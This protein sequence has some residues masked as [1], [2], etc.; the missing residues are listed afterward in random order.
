MQADSD[1]VVAGPD[2]AATFSRA[3]QPPFQ[4]PL[5]LPDNPVV[6]WFHLKRLAA[7]RV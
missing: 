4:I 2:G 6:S 1:P 3:I 7:I 5:A